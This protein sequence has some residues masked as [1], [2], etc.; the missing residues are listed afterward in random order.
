MAAPSWRQL[1]AIPESA[2][3]AQILRACGIE[4]PPEGVS[5]T[6]H[7][8]GLYVRHLA[9]GGAEW[10]VSNPGDDGPFTAGLHA[11]GSAAL[12]AC[13]CPAGTPMGDALRAFMR[14]HG[15]RPANERKAQPDHTR[16]IT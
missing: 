12:K 13:R 16:M 8:R 5:D 11:D 9:D 14:A 7:D 10:L 3:K 15:W 1:S 6:F 2:T 4:P